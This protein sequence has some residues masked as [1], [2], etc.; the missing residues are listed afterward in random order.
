[1]ELRVDRAAAWM[2]RLGPA[3]R[4]VV[5]LVLLAAVTG[6]IAL[7]KPHVP[8]LSLAVLYLLAILPVAVAWGLVYAAGVAVGGMLV[9]NFFFLP[10]L[11]TLSIQDSRNWFALLVFLV[12]A[13][14]VSDLAARSR[15]RAR[16]RRCSRRSPGRCSSRRTS[17]RHS[18]ASATSSRRALGV[19]TATIELSP[20]QH[21]PPAADTYPLV[22][23]GRRIGAVVMAEPPRA[24]TRRRGGRVLPALA[25]LL[26]VALE[27]ERLAREAFEAEALRRSDMI[28]TA[29][30]RAVSHDLRTPLMAILT[31][32]SALARP[33][34][35]LSG[36]GARRAARDGARGGAQARSSRRR[37]CSTSRGSRRARRRPRPSSWRSTISS[38]R[39]S[40]GSARTA[41]ASRCAAGRAAGGARRRAPDAARAREPARERAEVLVAGR[42]VSVR[43]SVTRQRGADPGRSTAARASPRPTA[44][45]SSRRSSA[46]RAATA[47]GAGLGLAIAQGFVEANGGRVWVESRTGQGA[48]FVLALPVDA[49]RG[50][51]VTGPRVLVVDD[52]AQ[53]LRALRTGLRAA[54]Y[55][56]DTAETGGGG[57]R[58]GR[59]AAA[60][61]GD[62]RPRAA[63]RPGT[64]V[65][66]ELRKWSSAPVIVLSAV[67][68]EREKVAALDAGADDYVTKPVGIDELLARL[69][70]VLRRV[71]PPGAPLVEVGDLAIDLEKQEV[72][73]DGKP[74]HLTPLQFDLL[75]VFARN[76]GKLLTHRML[77]R[78]VWGPGYGGDA[79][80]LRVHVA[81]LRR[82][83]ESDPARPRYLLTEPGA[84]YRLVDP[85]T[86]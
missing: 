10:P 75:R 4:S 35:V 74:V 77:I 11:H 80:L 79:N 7:L 73:V 31:S 23:G 19:G 9:F 53:I 49:R 13:V 69:R 43:V 24:G 60:G 36:D 42:A 1:M 65:C 62:P 61:G 45:G 48:T 85:A 5:C 12:T 16:N 63:R 64:E 70:A 40:R 39:R 55:K 33:D 29:I 78:E 59:A 76:V 71:A 86:R 41:S 27:R 2:S 57:A 6:V 52:E 72:R 81:Q 37:T 82:K 44:S 67:G 56:V 28:K 18:A 38:S 30:L 3:G 84:G 51:G 68:E 21:V 54:G 17:A 26:G 32:A 25:S 15:R 66:R 8:V 83:I 58:R 50:P 46:A 14:V 20:A 47:R 34:F 22:A